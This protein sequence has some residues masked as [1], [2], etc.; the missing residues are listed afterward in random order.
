MTK[1]NVNTLTYDAENGLV[2]YMGSSATY[3]YAY[4][5]NGL[6][7][8]KTP[9]AGSATAYIFSGS[10]VIAEY[11]AGAAAGSPSTEYIYSGAQLVAT[12]SGSTTTYQHPDQ[13]SARVSTDVNGN[14][15]RTF[16]HYPFGEVWY[17][18]GTTSKW[19]FTSYERDAEGN[20]YA[21]AR[22]YANRQG[23][24]L[25]P[26]PLTGSLSNPQSL[27]R[28][29]YSQNDPMNLRDP[30][31]LVTVWGGCYET[32]GPVVCLGFDGGG[33][34]TPDRLLLSIGD[35]SGGI[36]LQNLIPTNG[37]PPPPGYEQCVMEALQEVIATAEGTAGGMNDGYG[38]LVYGTVYSAPHPFHWLQGQTGTPANPIDLDPASLSGHPGIQVRWNPKYP[39][40]SAFGRY[41]IT[42]GTAAAF[43]ITDFSPRGQDAGTETMMQSLGMVAPAMQGN[44]ALSLARGNTTWASLPGAS[45]AGQHS[46]SMATAQSIFNNALANLPDCQ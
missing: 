24:F 45:A 15:V 29:G 25:S 3:T 32:E 38:R 10:K 31:G 26:D 37:P 44:L 39:T 13:L 14:P 7:V 40:S 17:E 36:P 33:S 6:R 9:P 43:G 11:T 27:N 1:D 22:I 28:Y 41:Q 16:G 19:K 42:V 46:I 30:S 8:E 34:G 23:R 4:D 18:T 20:D 5:G 35:P 2:K 21:L 12:I